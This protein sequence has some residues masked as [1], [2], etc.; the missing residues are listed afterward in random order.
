VK[1]GAGLLLTF[2]ILTHSYNP[3]FAQ[4]PNIKKP[5]K[6]KVKKLRGEKPKSNK[7]KLRETKF[8]TRNKKGDKARKG[9]IIGKKI[10]TK[11]SSKLFYF[12][13]SW[14]FNIWI[15]CKGRVIGMCEDKKS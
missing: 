6:E 8:K 14:F 15:L 13:F 10:K 3:S 1:F 12:F 7:R 5:R 11:S 2:F 9:D 4:D